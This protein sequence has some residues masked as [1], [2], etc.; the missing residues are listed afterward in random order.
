[1]VCTFGFS[2][3]TSKNY[4]LP[5]VENKTFDHLFPFL[6]PYKYDRKDILNTTF[7][8]LLTS[9]KKYLCKVDDLLFLYCYSEVFETLDYLNSSLVVN[10]EIVLT[11]W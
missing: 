8:V 2:I 10:K 6:S 9:F 7:I 5:L 11:L 3:A 4:C 1:M